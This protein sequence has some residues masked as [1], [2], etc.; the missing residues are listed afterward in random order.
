M[1]P[2]GV[3]SWIYEVVIIKLKQLIVIFTVRNSSRTATYLV[4]ILVRSKTI[5]GH[6]SIHAGG[7]I[8][9]LPPATEVLTY[10]PSAILGQFTTTIMILLFYKLDQGRDR[11][12]QN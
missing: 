2:R 9:T 8:T 4:V 6:K 7:A 10:I 1:P 5:N 11:I 3:G 12:S